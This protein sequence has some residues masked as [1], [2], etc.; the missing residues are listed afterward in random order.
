MERRVSCPP[1]GAD[2]FGGLTPEQKD[3]L[4]RQY[5]QH[6]EAE[7]QHHE[8]QARISFEQPHP[9]PATSTPTHQS[10][11]PQQQNMSSPS[12]VQ[13]AQQQSSQQPFGSS[14]QSASVPH[15]PLKPYDSAIAG[16]SASALSTPSISTGSLSMAN[17]VLAN[18]SG[19]D[20]PSQSALHVGS[21][22]NAQQFLAN[23]TDPHMLLI[24]GSSLLSV[25][26][27]SPA[28]LSA[29]AHPPPPP[30]STPTNAMLGITSL[31]GCGAGAGGQNGGQGQLTMAFAN[32]LAQAALERGVDPSTLVQLL[33]SPKLMDVLLSKAGDLQQHQVGQFV[34]FCAPCRYGSQSSA[35]AQSR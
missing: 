18:A 33:Q 15:T 32:A 7:R 24:P 26:A 8:R 19:V 13:S 5:T 17:N 25:H 27:P 28:Q 9:A 22:L 20:C 30:P 6:I 1:S 31:Q 34:L 29:T 23:A 16:L 10:F 35:M 4:L 2:F 11:L 3:E 21:P 14:Q 12:P